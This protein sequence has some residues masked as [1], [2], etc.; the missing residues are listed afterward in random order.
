MANARGFTL[1]ELL[2]LIAGLGV[3]GVI[4]FG[5]VRSC[6]S[7]GGKA[8]DEARRFVSEMGLRV[9]GVTCSDRDTDRDGYVSCTVSVDNDGKTHLEAI[10][11]AARYTWN[12]GCR[13][14]KPVVYRNVN[15]P[16]W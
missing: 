12:D 10:E 8:K 15:G 14:Q 5:S 7:S 4:L 1:Y 2:I 6:V 11:C 16:R 13:M 9:N 3:I